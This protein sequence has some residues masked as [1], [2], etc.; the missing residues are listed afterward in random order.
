VTEPDEEDE[1][2]TEAAPTSAADDDGVSAPL[3]I[4]LAVGL[5]G[6]LVLAGWLL[7]R[8]RRAS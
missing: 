1:E 5:A 4:A 8:R 7:A 2:E 6:V 3:L